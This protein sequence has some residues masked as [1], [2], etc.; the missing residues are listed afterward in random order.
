MNFERISSQ[1]YV[2]LQSLAKIQER[3]QTWLQH[4]KNQLIEVL[5]KITK[6]IHLEW[7]IGLQEY[8]DHAPQ[9][10]NLEAVS[11]HLKNSYS[12]I[13]LKTIDSVKSYIKY[14]GMLSYAQ[15]YNRTITATIYFPFIEQW[16]EK[17]EP[18]IL[19]NYEPNELN[20][21]LIL[22]HVEEFLQ[23]MT[24]WENNKREPIGFDFA[25]NMEKVKK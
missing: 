23:E 3:H 1:S 25:R 6:Q 10:I 4:T 17:R 7:Y 16:V 11:L 14:G 9:S 5:E 19:G 22:S 2:Y 24:A 12:G 13:V 18:I 20:E 15:T 8:N 21:N